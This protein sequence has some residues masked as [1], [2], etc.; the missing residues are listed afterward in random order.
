M[1]MQIFARWIEELSKLFYKTLICFRSE[2]ESDNLRTLYMVI[3]RVVVAIHAFRKW[4]LNNCPTI[5][6]FSCYSRS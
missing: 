1:H 2:S 6:G 3:L 4:T 5:V